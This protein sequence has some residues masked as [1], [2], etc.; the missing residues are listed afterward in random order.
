MVFINSEVVCWG[1][2]PTDYVV[3]SLKTS[4]TVDVST[5]IPT[6]TTSGSIGSMSMGAL[7]GLGGYMTLG[8]GAKAKPCVATLNESEAL[9][10]KDSEYY[11]NSAHLGF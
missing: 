5:P 6:A 8:L 1:H 3:T 7:S 10:A 9:I 4:S 11:A 2:T